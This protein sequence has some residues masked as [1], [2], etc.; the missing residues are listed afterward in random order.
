MRLTLAVGRAVTPGKIRWSGKPTMGE[1]EQQ[2]VLGTNSKRRGRVLIAV[3]SCAGLA[4]SII[5][6]ALLRRAENFH[7]RAD[8]KDKATE[9]AS[10]VERSIESK[11]V[12]LASLQAFVTTREKLD[13]RHFRM[14]VE[15]LL[16]RVHGIQGLAWLP[17]VRDAD[18]AAFEAAAQRDGLPGFQITERN[19]QGQMVR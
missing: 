2:R 1:D 14:F 18:R 6:F 17:R 4:V 5:I 19:A 15:P 12:V 10:A 13:R 11:F 9:H 8:F 16:A 3:V 7:I